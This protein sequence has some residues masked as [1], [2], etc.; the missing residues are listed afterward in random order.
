MSVRSVSFAC[1]LAV[2]FV[3]AGCSGGG[4]EAPGNP[5]TLF[6]N[7]ISVPAL[8]GGAIPFGSSAGNNDAVVQGAGFVP[9]TTVRF[10]GTLSPQVVF[11]SNTEIRATTPAH[12]A[13]T[14]DVVLRTPSGEQVSLTGAFA[15]IDPPTILAV[16]AVT[17]PTTGTSEASVDGGHTFVV[18]G[19]NFKAG[20]EVFVDDLPVN[21]QFL[22]VNQVQFT[23]LA[24]N[25]EVPV[26]VDVRNPEGLQDGLPNGIFYTAAF[27]FQPH[28]EALSRAEAAHLLRRMGFGAPIADVNLAVADGMSNTIDRHLTIQSNDDQTEQDALTFYDHP[29]P[30]SGINNNVNK[31]WWIH[32][33]RNNSNPFQE[34][35]A[36]FLHDH[37]ATSERNMSGDSRWT[38]HKQINLFRRFCLGT[39]QTLS[40][41][42]PGLN[43]DW[44]ALLVEVAKDRA[45][46]DWLDGRLSTRNNPNENWARELW[47]LFML[48]EGRGY[49][50]NDIIEASK[51]FTG[52]YWFRPFPTGERYLDHAYRLTRHDEREKTIFGVTGN[53]GYDNIA[54]FLEGNS[55]AQTDT[56]DTDGGVVA[57]TLAQRPAE[58]STFIC[59]KLLVYFL[60]D[61]PSPFVVGELA[62]DLVAADWDLKPVIEKMLK[63]KAMYSNAAV[64][65]KVKS[66]VE[67]VIGYLR[68]T[69]LDLR[70]NDGD[71]VARI[72]NRMFAIGQLVIDP[73]DVNGWPGGNAWLGAQAML[74]R[75][76]FVNESL[77]LINRNDFVN[78]VEPLLPPVS[79]R[80]PPGLVSHFASMLDA[81]LTTQ[82]T[83]EFEAYVADALNSSGTPVAF[84]PA[85]PFI[86]TSK[87]RGLIYML[88]QYHNAHQQ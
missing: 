71:N 54:P 65:R 26:D 6:F 46:L 37:F 30:A 16:Q 9:G 41:G 73:P 51:A 83:S 15:Y 5:Q 20:A 58:A 14:V 79:E 87:T 61:D 43:Y 36:F 2:T 49:T 75:I 33:L 78:T 39:S 48:G 67:Y 60:Y 8:P 11:V 56:R 23:S 81:E 45:M 86:M 17:G 70:T 3:V 24:H 68:S 34:K 77:G 84:D 82:A 32:I 18:T 52:F 27:S 35:L 13:G 50:Q 88:A 1:A 4:G 80:T 63:S 42:E 64:K 10:D 44:E 69:G 31:E 53:F 57:L 38:M 85:D 21:E 7:S 28:T 59:E 66:P 40:N 25:A 29:L 12:A 74:E 72:R 19:L 62:A 76:N 22:S 47:E 55:A